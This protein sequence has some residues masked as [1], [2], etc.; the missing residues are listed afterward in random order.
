MK[1]F[2]DTVKKITVGVA[3]ASLGVLLQ[4]E[5][6]TKTVL[7]GQFINMLTLN[8]GSAKVSQFILTATTATNANVLIYDTYTNRT[9]QIVQPYT[10]TISYATNQISIVTNYFNVIQ[11]YTNLV[12]LDITNNAVPLGTNNFN[13]TV[14]GNAPANTSIVLGSPFVNYWFHQGIWVTNTGSGAASVTLTYQQ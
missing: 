14:G 12:L 5:S 9:F 3:I 7:G 10:N 13:P 8:N 1:L 6:V 11:N 4:A 2:N